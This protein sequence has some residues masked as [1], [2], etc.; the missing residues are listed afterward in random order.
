MKQ[1]FVFAVCVFLFSAAALHAELRVTSVQAV[2][3]NPW[4]TLGITVQLAGKPTAGCGNSL[5]LIA[6]DLERDVYL[7]PRTVAG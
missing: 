4:G 1:I 3:R 6:H 2:P 7:T 5:M